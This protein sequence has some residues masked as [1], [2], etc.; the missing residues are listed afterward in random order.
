LK[1]SPAKGVHPLLR[2]A[3]LDGMQSQLDD[4][5]EQLAEYEALQW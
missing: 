4:L 1:A 3:E 5:N 2:E